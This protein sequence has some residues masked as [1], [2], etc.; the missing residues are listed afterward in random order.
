MRKS[1][2]RIGPLVNTS[3]RRKKGLKGAQ[4]VS[5]GSSNQDNHM[6]KFP[7]ILIVF[8]LFTETAC[9]KPKIDHDLT[10]E[11]GQMLIVGFRGTEID[12]KS[13]IYTAIKELNLG[14]VILFDR[15]TPGK[16]FPRNITDPEQVREL[17]AAL[18]HI[19]DTPLIIAV[20][21][22]GGR[23]NRLKP[24][25]GFIEVPSHEQLGRINSPETTYREINRLA[26]QLSELGINTNFAPVVD[27]NRNPDNPVIAKLERSF[28]ADPEVVANQAEAFIKAHHDNGR[29]TAIKHFPGHGSST[30]DT[31]IGLTDVTDTYSIIEL[32]PFAKLIKKRL[33]DMV[34]TS[35]IINRNFDPDYPVTLSGYYIKNILRKDFGYDGVVV[36]DDM[37]MGAITEHFSF[38]EAIIRAINAGCDLL[39]ISNNGSTYDERAPYKAVDIIKDAL[40]AGKISEA[41]IIRS[42]ERIQALKSRLNF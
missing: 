10:Q 41:Q 23:I 31:H 3:S 40:Q 27:L 37:Q 4:R 17:C 16:S 19:S 36:S 12:E 25:Y 2:R 22:E 15:D 14:G 20:D 11:I 34:M 39:I 42:L 32:Q 30:G 35:H 28:S 7:L 24:K 8:L 26:K 18:Q 6:K 21:A 9:T 13:Y 5:D 38:A 1:E 29:L 33:V